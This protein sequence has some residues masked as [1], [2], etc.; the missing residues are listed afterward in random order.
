MIVQS[1]FLA[2][3]M[4]GLLASVSV[5]LTLQAGVTRIFNFAHG[6][7]VMLGAYVVYYLHMHLGIILAIAVAGLAMGLFSWAI[8]TLVLRRVLKQAAHDQLLATLGISI[9]VMNVALMAFSPTPRLIQT[10]ELLPTLV[11][12]EVRLPGNNV[13][14]A[15]VGFA[16]Y[17]GLWWFVERSR[18]GLPM[19]FSSADAEL[20]TYTGIDVDRMFTL[21][22]VIG[23]VF[24]G[25]AGGLIATVLAIH[26][27]MGFDFVIR[28]FA[29]IM[30]G[31]IGS[32]PGALLGA[33][34]LAVTEGLSSALL[35]HGASWSFGVAFVV[36]LIVLVV[37]PKGLLTRAG[38][39]Q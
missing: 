9:V 18:W 27:S 16:M 28:A 26:P 33:V 32:V 20:A 10:P 35:P 5:G 19:R 1:I 31:G 39:S 14:A 17:A 30:M 37:R 8:F 34:I 6:E 4:A 36:L 29:I 15:L 21:S 38:T 2:L 23:G 12:G 24:G 13:F 22:F 25:V 7:I 3:L 11:F